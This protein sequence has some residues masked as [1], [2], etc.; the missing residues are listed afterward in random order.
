VKRNDHISIDGHA[1]T[2]TAV[3]ST[4]LFVLFDSGDEVAY[5]LHDAYRMLDSGRLVKAQTALV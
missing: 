2:I 1:A 4:H 3:T 5:R